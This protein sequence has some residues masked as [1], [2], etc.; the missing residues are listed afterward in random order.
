MSFRGVGAVAFPDGDVFHEA[1]F[2]GAAA[3]FFSG[4][5]GYV[6]PG[7]ASAMMPSRV[8]MRAIPV[9]TCSV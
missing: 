3:V 7:W 4:P 6:W 5:A 2:G 8:P 9:M 1:A